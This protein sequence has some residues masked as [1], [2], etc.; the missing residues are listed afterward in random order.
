MRLDKYICKSTEHSKS[1]AIQLINSGKVQVNNI[2]ITDESIQVHENNKIILNGQAL[3]TREFRY[4]LVHKPL[5]TICSNIDEAY[6]SLFNCL[7]I[8]RVSELHVVGRLDVDTTGLVLVTD[9]GRWTFDIIRPEMQCKKVYCV[10]LSRAITDD[11]ICKLEKG[12]KLHGDPKLTLPAEVTIIGPKEVLLTITEGR[13]HQVKRMLTAVGNKVVSLHREKIG[14]I[15]LDVDIG[16]WRY[17]T[18]NEVKS[19]NITE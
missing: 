17:L 10:G 11:A 8:E 16:Q 6:P 1:E 15:S 18:P 3:K 2:I 7:D 5:N 4:A 13:Y 12:L 9:D 19:F 14:S